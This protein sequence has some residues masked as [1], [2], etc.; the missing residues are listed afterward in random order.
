VTCDVSK[1]EDLKYLVE[2]TIERFGTVDVLINNANFEADRKLFLD[3]DIDM[4]DAGLH[5]GVY[6]H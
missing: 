6:A 4:S 3:Q 2:K 5:T 1:Y